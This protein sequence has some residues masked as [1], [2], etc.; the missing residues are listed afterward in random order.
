M[1]R[2]QLYRRSKGIIIRWRRVRL[3]TGAEEGIGI[4]AGTEE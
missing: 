2:K 3:V 1:D 4:V